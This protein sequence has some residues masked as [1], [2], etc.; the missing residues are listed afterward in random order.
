MKKTD[1]LFIQL[2]TAYATF[3]VDKSYKIFRPGGN[4][5]LWLIN[6]TQ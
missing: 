3:L 5:R 2:K 1:L 4:L 6:A